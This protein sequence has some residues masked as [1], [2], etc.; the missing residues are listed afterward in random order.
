MIKFETKI[1]GL[2]MEELTETSYK[3]VEILKWNYWERWHSEALSPFITPWFCMGWFYGG[4]N[5]N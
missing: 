5:R 4:L 1:Y 2:F 3:A